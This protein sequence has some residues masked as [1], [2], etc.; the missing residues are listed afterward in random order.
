MY[1][2]RKVGVVVPAYDEEK[3]IGRVIETMPDL[4][5]RIVVRFT[6]EYLKVLCKERVV[7]PL[8]TQYPA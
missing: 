4:V 5:D 2:E 1:R 7:Y 3:L 6:S 8:E